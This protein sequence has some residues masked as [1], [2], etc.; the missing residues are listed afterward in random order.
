MSIDDNMTC[1]NHEE[2]DTKIVHHW[3]T[4]SVKF[5][6]HLI[7]EPGIGRSQ[8]PNGGIFLL[9]TKPLLG[10][11]VPEDVHGVRSVFPEST[12][13]FIEENNNEELRDPPFGEII[14][15]NMGSHRPSST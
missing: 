4:S 9:S 14:H 6:D 1:E 12:Q 2:A 7:C 13:C 15:Y 8:Y 10:N 3:E 11:K 5:T